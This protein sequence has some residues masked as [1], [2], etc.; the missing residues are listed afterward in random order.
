M[1]V[2]SHCLAD[3]DAYNTRASVLQ[4]LFDDRIRDVTLGSQLKVLTVT[5]SAAAR[6]SRQQH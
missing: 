2:G 3:S 6:A 1:L 4:G 5:P